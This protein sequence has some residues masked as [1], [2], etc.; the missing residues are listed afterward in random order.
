M[1]GHS[2]GGYITLAFAEKYPELLSAFGLFH[3]TAFP[4]SEEKKINR[5]KSIE[6]IKEHGAFEFLRTTSPNLFSAISTNRM[7]SEIDEFIN[8][9]NKFSADSLIAYY[10]AMMQRPDRVSVLEKTNLPVLFI[11]GQY[12]NPAP[13]NDVL[14]Q[15]H[16]PERSF[17]YILTESG[18]MG[19][20][21]E[22]AK[23]NKAFEEFLN[24][25]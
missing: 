16:L 10:E 5:R 9:L 3:S 13:M 24:N 4:D 25:I 14:K 22:P 12:D 15:C 1:I 19:T 2:M 11:T 23:S 21:E 18:H 8:G 17:I 20:M 7:K 6:F